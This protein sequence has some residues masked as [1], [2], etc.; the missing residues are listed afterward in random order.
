MSE[1]PVIAMAG[2]TGF[3]GTALRRKLRGSYHLRALTRSTTRAAL[4][5]PDE[6]ESW[7][8]C[9]LFS[10]REVTA[11]LAGAESAIY[12]VHSMLPSARL[13]QSRFED[14][15]LLLA[16]NFGRAAEA[17]GLKR[18]LYLGGL[19]PSGGHALSGHLRSRHEVEETLRSYRTPVT[20]IRT[21][22][23]VGPGGSSLRMLVNLVRRLPIMLLPRWLHSR[24]YA[25]AIEDIV[26]AFEHALADPAIGAGNFDIGHPEQLTYGEMIRRCA[27]V[28]E[29][30]RLLIPIPLRSTEISKLWIQLFSGAPAALTGPLVD[31]LRHDL[32]L[33]PNPLQDRIA[34]DAQRFESALRR[35][36]D[37]RGRVL[38]NQRARTQQKDNALIRTERR[39]RSVQRVPAPPRWDAQTCADAYFTWLGRVLRS[40]LRVENDDG[41]RR[42]RL[43]GVHTVLLELEPTEALIDERLAAYTITGG[44]LADTRADVPGRLEFRKVLHGDSLLTAIH[45]YR[46]RLPWHFYNLTQ[47]LLHLAVMRAFGRYM[48]ATK[49][50]LEAGSPPAA[51]A[52]GE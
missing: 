17:N 49:R 28:L 6:T 52:A 47:A 46:P 37:S 43:R 29:R 41:T 13:N 50:Q 26:R 25:I 3:V 18:I 9:D 12:L 22:I 19:L 34:D 15:D 14:L 51:D 23:I 20:V 5:R 39:V 32:E 4:A 35:S 45:A 8:Q 1:R 44:L 40:F 10:L 24:T 16:D 48:R 36:I 33:S 31:S 7:Q 11:A 30:K 21:G 38:P 2:A 27:R 42:I